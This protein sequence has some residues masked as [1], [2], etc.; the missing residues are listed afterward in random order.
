MG[1]G[2]SR[3][4][5][6]KLCAGKDNN[7]NQAQQLYQN[8]ANSMTATAR[9]AERMAE[10]MKKRY[11]KLV[12]KRQSQFGH[13][14]AAP[15]PHR[16]K[17]SVASATGFDSDLP[18]EKSVMPLGSKFV[19]KKSNWGSDKNLLDRNR[20][21]KELEE[22]YILDCG[23]LL[24]KGGFAS[25]VVVKGRSNADSYAMK[26]QKL[27]EAD[28]LEEIRTEI[29][30]QS[31]LD[32]PNIGKIFEFYEDAINREISIIMEYMSG[33]SVQELLNKKY[34]FEVEEVASILKKLVG[35]IGY[36]HKHGVVHRDIKPANMVYESKAPDAEIKLID[37]GLAAQLAGADVMI[38][39]MGTVKFMAPELWDDILVYDS[40]V[41]MWA[42][43]VTAY[44][45]LAGKLPFRGKS[46]EEVLENISIARPDY[47]CEPWDELPEDCMKF[48]Q[49]L[50]RK[51]PSERPPATKALEHRFFRNHIHK[52]TSETASETLK[53]K[54]EVVDALFTFV[55]ADPLQKLAIE[56]I[57][58]ATSPAKMQEIRHLFQKVQRLALPPA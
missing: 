36:C 23:V 3:E 21:M 31:G 18:T 44:V 54:T 47:G 52:R 33:G 17:T 14:P 6:T 53:R 30:T 26:V 20:S 55:R 57:A 13:D 51:D 42:I 12:K 35:A 11:Q 29:A 37:F 2:G 38:G 25:V 50:M 49:D 43:G 4:E 40:S 8:Y 19:R 24:G 39:Q 34:V 1:C 32:H 48:C 56:I 10:I 41:D 22:K 45:L 5:P 15:Q 28:D 7:P 9:N 16:R 58:F 27:R 46:Q